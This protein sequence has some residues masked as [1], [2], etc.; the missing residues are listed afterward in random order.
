MKPILTIFFLVAGSAVADS[1]Y[2]TQTN[3]N[4]PG[5]PVNVAP[6]PTAD[7]QYIGAPQIECDCTATQVIV[8]G[9]PYSGVTV[10]TSSSTT[11]VI[12]PRT[13]FVA[14]ISLLDGTPQGCHEPIERIGESWLPSTV[15]IPTGNTIPGIASSI[16]ISWIYVDP[17]SEIPI[18]YNRGDQWESY[19]DGNVI[20]VNTRTSP[21][22]C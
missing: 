7:F 8:S 16:D 1:T 14:G 6:P 13:I 5:Q 12:N 21:A 4:P 10:M 19:C 22:P 18:P 15:D 20:E 3:V 17:V 11:H 2:W 9:D